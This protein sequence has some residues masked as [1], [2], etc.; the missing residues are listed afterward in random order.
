MRVYAEYLKKE[1][2]RIKTLLQFGD[3]TDLIGSAVLANPGSAAPIS[4]N[5]DK[6]IIAKFYEK[7]HNIEMK[8]CNWCLFDRDP[9]MK[10]LEKIFNGW[11]VNKTIELNGIIQLFN[12]FYDMDPNRENAIMQFSCKSKYVFNESQYFLNKPVFFGWGDLNKNAELKEFARKIFVDYNCKDN[13]VYRDGFDNNKFY[14]PKYIHFSYKRDEE[15]KR[16]LEEFHKL[17]VD[18]Q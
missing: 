12:C 4:D 8:L 13:P 1:N 6:T 3:G 7:T 11:Y 9:T 10:W 2:V 15:V 5:F 14:H 18:T 16:I 17:V